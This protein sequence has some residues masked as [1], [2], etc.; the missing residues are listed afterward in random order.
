MASKTSNVIRYDDTEYDLN[1]KED[2]IELF[3][4]LVYTINYLRCEV[5]DLRR[6]FDYMSSRAVY[7]Y[8]SEE[9]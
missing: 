8:N 4:D 3:N 9:E 1:D 6:D 5:R 7:R 2:V